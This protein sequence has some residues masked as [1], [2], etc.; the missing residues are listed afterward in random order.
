M[1]ED[2]DEEFSVMQ[3]SSDLVFICFI[4]VNC[5][6]VMGMGNLSG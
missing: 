6:I 1:D 4:E 3:G 5:E 2:E